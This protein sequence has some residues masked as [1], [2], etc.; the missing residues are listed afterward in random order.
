MVKIPTAA[1]FM[2]A[3]NMRC[4]SPVAHL[5]IEQLGNAILALKESGILRELSAHDEV[6]K[7][8][9]RMMKDFTDEELDTC[10]IGGSAN[11]LIA[12]LGMTHTTLVAFVHASMKSHG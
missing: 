10:G 9:E 1:D 7:L 3:V 6:V 12:L 4:K 2:N 8:C 5:L 11:M